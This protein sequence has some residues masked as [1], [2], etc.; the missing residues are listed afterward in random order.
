MHQ[1]ACKLDNL[2]LIG[3]DRL[4]RASEFVSWWLYENLPPFYASAC[5]VSLA[6]RLKR[7]AAAAGIDLGLIERSG[8]LAVE[9]LVLEAMNARIGKP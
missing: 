9:R 7:G 2:D 8:P 1:G 6:A 5:V 3:P 4:D